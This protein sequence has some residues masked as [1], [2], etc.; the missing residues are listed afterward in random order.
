MF[1]MVEVKMKKEN[2]KLLQIILTCV[3][4]H[5]IALGLFL[6]FFTDLFYTFFFGQPVENIFFVRQSGIFLILAG[7][8]YS[9]PLLDINKYYQLIWVVIISKISA[10]LFLITNAHHTPKPAMILLATAGDASMAVLL[11]IFLKKCLKDNLFV[12]QEQS[13]ITRDA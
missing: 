9:F 7:L 5:S 10:V 8:F 13:S 6:Y 12:T 11:I 1:E 4:I 2:V 3:G